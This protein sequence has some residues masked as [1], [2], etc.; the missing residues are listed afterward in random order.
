MTTPQAR[1]AEALGILQA[2]GMPK[3]QL[4]ERTAITLLA[5]LNLSVGTPWQQASS[6][7]LG[8]RA[9]LDFARQQMERNYAENTRESVRKYSVKQLVAA[10]ILLHNPD[11][12]SR[13]VNSADN[14]YQ[15]E[16]QALSLFQQFGSNHWDTALASYLYH[17]QL[18]VRF[19]YF[20][21]SKI[22]DHQCA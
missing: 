13:A 3:E 22:V 21:D 4:N 6:P 9:I 20:D 8:I 14:C 15:I 7:L 10:G 2:L 12:P 17:R 18:K 11:K 1:I 16:P 5:L 19:S